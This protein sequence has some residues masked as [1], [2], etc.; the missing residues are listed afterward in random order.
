MYNLIIQIPVKNQQ[1]GDISVKKAESVAFI[2]FP[3][4]FSTGLQQYV[5]GQWFSTNEYSPNT[6]AYANIDIGS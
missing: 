5:L 6:V 3:Q 4:N 1:E 2:Q